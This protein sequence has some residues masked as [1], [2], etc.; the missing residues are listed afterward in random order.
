MLPYLLW[1]WQPTTTN[2]WGK[3]L[4]HVRTP[5][6][7]PITEV[8]RARHHGRHWSRDHGGILLTD[9]LYL[10]TFLLHFKKIIY[11]YVYGYFSCMS[12]CVSHVC[13]VPVET[14]RGFWVSWSWSY[15]QLWVSMWVLGFEPRASGRA[16]STLNSAVFLASSSAFLCNP[17]PSAQD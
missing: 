15:R 11:L 10:L 8:H 1:L 2:L 17:E 7:Q 16:A 9:L 5:R 13:P 14:S 12:V 3:A 6:T 4:F